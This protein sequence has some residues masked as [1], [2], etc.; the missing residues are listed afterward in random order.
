MGMAF[1]HARHQEFAG[2]IEALGAVG[3]N[4]LGLRRDGHDALALDQHLAGKRRGAGAIPHHRPVDQQAHCFL[5]LEVVC[6][7]PLRGV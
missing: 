4:S 1:D 6:S 5:R 3:C 2:R 7:A